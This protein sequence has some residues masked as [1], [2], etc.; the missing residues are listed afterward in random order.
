[1][2]PVDS[3]GPVSNVPTTGA[4]VDGEFDRSAPVSIPLDFLQEL[5][6]IAQKNL[7]RR[8]P[9]LP[10]ARSLGADWLDAV[11]DVSSPTASAETAEVAYQIAEFIIRRK[12]EI[13]QSSDLGPRRGLA[14]MERICR[15]FEHV[16]A[17]GGVPIRSEEIQ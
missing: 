6:T 17:S 15:M 13:E 14:V 7:E 11:A 2:K 16:F 10:L 4:V 12:E 5:S 8:P 1:M 3:N 9:K